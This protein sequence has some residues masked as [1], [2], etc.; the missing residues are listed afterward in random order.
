LRRLE[1][2]AT[3]AATT[4]QA[5][6]I[7]D[8]IARLHQEFHGRGAGR[9]HGFLN[10]GNLM[11]LM[12]DIYTPL[13]RTLIDSGQFEMVKRSRQAF[14]MAMRE[15]FS[16][17]VETITGKRVVAFMS[18]V[19]ESPPCPSRSSSSALRESGRHRV[20]HQRGTAHGVTCPRWA[21][22]TP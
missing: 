10:D 3:S 13:E 11:V 15:K 12:S 8:E 9:S 6:T 2:L 18:Q 19:H 4:D 7:A 14:Q 16:A 22:P 1:R 21:G 17:A 20:A 5:R